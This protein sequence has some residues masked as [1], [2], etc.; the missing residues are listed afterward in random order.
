MKQNFLNNKIIFPLIMLL[1]FTGCTTKVAMKTWVPP[2][3]TGQNIAAKADY[4]IIVNSHKGELLYDIMED[5]L[6]ERF[7]ELPFLTVEGSLSPVELSGQLKDFNLRPRIEMQ[8]RVAFLRYEVKENSEVL[9]SQ[10]VRLV[11]LRRC[12]YLL[13]KNQCTVIGTATLREGLQKVNYVQSVSLSLKDADG[14]QI[15]PDQSF[16]RVYS[17]SMK[18]VPDEI[19]LRKKVSNLIAREYTKQILPYRESFDI[20]LL[21]GDSIALEMIEKGAYSFAFKRLEKLIT[22]DAGT[23]KTA[24]NLYLQGVS[25]EF[26]SDRT[27]ASSFYNEALLLDPGNEIILAAVNRIKKASLV[28]KKSI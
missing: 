22:H 1:Y 24:E 14:N 13:E 9:R 3:N 28:S 15:V 20:V 27:G 25:L 7:T 12:N 23:E 21:D 5:A 6:R 18:M 26:Q 8:G 10:S 11:S 4:L 19:V 17:K 2:Q 16:E